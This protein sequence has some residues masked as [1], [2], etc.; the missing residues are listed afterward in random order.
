VLGCAGGYFFDLS[1]EN[2]IADDAWV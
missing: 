2:T 1:Y